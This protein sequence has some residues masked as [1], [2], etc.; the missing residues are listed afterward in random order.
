M[1]RKK[2]SDENKKPGISIT[3]DNKLD[4]IME[5]YLKENNVNRSK[6]I[7]HLIRKDFE[8][9]GYNVTPYSKKQ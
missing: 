6:Y 9:K 8:S 2:L 7:E 5:D 4:D 3:I 1:S